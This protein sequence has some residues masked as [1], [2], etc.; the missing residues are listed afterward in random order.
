MGINLLPFPVSPHHGLPN[1]AC[2][3]GV[4]VWILIS[5]G[6]SGGKIK[7]GVISQATYYTLHLP[8]VYSYLQNPWDDSISLASS[9]GFLLHLGI[10]W[11]SPLILYPHWK[12][13]LKNRNPECLYSSL[14]SLASVIS[15]TAE[16]LTCLLC[17]WYSVKH[18]VCQWHRINNK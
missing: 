4:F 17:L 11:L 16:T 7:Q 13:N 12:Q 3:P 18:N 2:L 10:L 14:K 6:C 5:M 15:A 9:K 8:C 1:E